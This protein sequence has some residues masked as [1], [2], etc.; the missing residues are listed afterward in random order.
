MHSQI[1]RLRQ[2]VPILRDVDL[3]IPV[4][5]SRRHGEVELVKTDEISCQAGVGQRRGHGSE[6]ERDR[7]WSENSNVAFLPAIAGLS[8][9]RVRLQAGL[10]GLGS[11][12]RVVGVG[13]EWCPIGVA[14]A[15]LLSVRQHSCTLANPCSITFFNLRSNIYTSSGG[16][17]VVVQHAAQTLAPLDLARVTLGPGSGLMSR[18]AKP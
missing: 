9:V 14:R 17:V 5:K 3:I 16:A 7:V 1:H 4:R 2:L 6:R 13:V 12:Q 8:G 15:E 11:A 10:G 18:F